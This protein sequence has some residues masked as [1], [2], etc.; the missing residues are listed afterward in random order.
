[1]VFWGEIGLNKSANRYIKFG[2][3]YAISDSLITNVDQAMITPEEMLAQTSLS[4]PDVD[5][6]SYVSKHNIP[7]TFVLGK[8]A[9]V[10][11]DLDWGSTQSWQVAVRN[12]QS[13]LRRRSAQ[14]IER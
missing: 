1:M 5:V 12:S 2:E 11:E 13:C 3:I 4:T 8:V 14:K 6:E 9:T 10:F 7:R